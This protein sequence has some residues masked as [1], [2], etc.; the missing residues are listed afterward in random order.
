VAIGGSSGGIDL[1]TAANYAILTKAGSTNVPNSAI[2]GGL[3]TSP[4]S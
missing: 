4:I 2:T 3:G 1:R